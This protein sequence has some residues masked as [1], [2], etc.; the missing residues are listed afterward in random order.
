MSKGLFCGRRGGKC[1]SSPYLLVFICYAWG[2]DAKQGGIFITATTA[3]Q[4][5]PLTNSSLFWFFKTRSHYTDQAGLNLVV[6]LLQ[7]TRYGIISSATTPSFRSILTSFHLS[8]IAPFLMDTLTLACIKSYYMLHHW[9]SIWKLS[10]NSSQ[11]LGSP[12]ILLR[13]GIFHFRWM[14]WRT[15]EE[16]QVEKYTDCFHILRM[17]GTV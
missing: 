6:S 12:G 9:N 7:P 15:A 1:I 4:E 8:S 3:L 10:L 5:P 17:L 11:I 16:N 14:L 13:Q 2:G